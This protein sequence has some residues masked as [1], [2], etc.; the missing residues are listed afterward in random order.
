VC[1]LPAAFAELR[2]EDSF[3]AE[4]FGLAALSADDAAGA[5]VARA[6]G[7]SVTLIPA[8][9][10]PLVAVPELV[11]RLGTARCTEGLG[12]ELAESRMGSTWGG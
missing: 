12:V 10:F 2:S 11:P 9:C 4:M 7:S 1:S 6:I 8:V 5:P 3:A